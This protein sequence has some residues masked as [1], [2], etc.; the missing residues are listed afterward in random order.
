MKQVL[1]SAGGDIQVYDVPVPL[2]F[3]DA[4]LVRNAFSIISSGTEGSAVT[5][6]S[7][8][9]GIYEKATASRSRV[10]QVWKMAKTGGVLK[11]YDAVKSKL[12]EY[13]PIGY[14]TAGVVVET[15]SPQFPFPP[16]TRVACMGAGLASHAEYVAIPRN[17]MAR[18]PDGVALEEAAF[19]AIACI[20]MQGIRRLDLTPG[21]NIGVIGL[22]LIGQITVR[23]LAAMGY[24]A[25]AADLDPARVA[26]ATGISGV[27]GWT[28]GTDDGQ[29]VAMEATGGV[30][31]DGVIICAATESDAPVN[32]AFDLL[33]PRGRVSIVGDVGLGLDRAKMYRKELELRLSCSYGPGRYDG[34]Y[35]MRGNDYPIAHA[36]WTEGRNLAYFLELLGSGRLSLASLVS[37]TFDI[38]DAKQAYAAV[39]EGGV[40]GVALDYALPETPA[41]PTPAAH[42]IRRKDS[43]IKGAN[44]RVGLGIIGVGS[45]TRG[46]HLPNAK[47]LDSLFDLSGMAS[48]SGATAA[49]AAERYDAEI[50]TSDYLVLL[51]DDG[52]DAVLIG[53]RHA[54]HAKA[55]LDA[56]DAGKHVY[57]EKPMTTTI[58]DGEAV[59][60]KAEET[61]LVVR[62]GFNRRFA[63]MLR[64]LR[65]GIGAGGTRALSMRV[66]IGPL[67][68]DWSNTAEEGGRFLGEATHFLD[69]ANWF[70]GSEPT[71]LSAA[72]T[73]PADLTNPNGAL[74]L[75]YAGGSMAQLLYTSLGSG[76][77]GKEHFNA[78]GNGRTGTVDD[79][80]A[81]TLSDRKR[82]SRNGSGEKGQLEALREFGEAVRGNP[83]DGA[84]ARAGLAAT[85]MAVEA[86]E[87]AIRMAEEAVTGFTA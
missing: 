72:F 31:L 29:S 78:F 11:T 58:E 40:Y 33:R 13:A 81:L 39:K 48:R 64:D 69:L 50:A 54:A 62:V 66:D 68:D 15:D 49:A 25:F 57:V 22:G 63:P 52:I 4:A 17:L 70:M 84:D 3:S 6:H 71:S 59:L 2:R 51:E 77:M 1:L 83:R 12:K 87:I 44:D 9:R 38:A 28:I 32:S 55:I 8:A 23:M 35:E 65:D 61:G 37:K 85:R 30:G 36:R 41:I 46:M 26:D 5:K 16:G 10:E 42:T 86:R 20:A 82:P 79:Y 18:V 19:A 80:T 14:S 60:A 47:K 56:L 74:T 75:G 76:K 7:G 67:G 27:K 53:T 24:N 21:E 45:F 34:N 43:R 73:D